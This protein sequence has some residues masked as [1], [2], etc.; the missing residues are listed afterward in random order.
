MQWAPYPG[1]NGFL[2]GGVPQPQ[3]T[4][5]TEEMFLFVNAK[6][7]GNKGQIFL[8][9]PM[10]FNVTTH[11][12]K[13]VNLHIY[14]QGA[15]ESGKKPGYI[16]LRQVVQQNAGR[17]VRC[18]VGGGDGTVMWFDSEATKH[19]VDTTTQV[20]LGIMPLGTGNDFSRVAGWG[21]NNPEHVEDDDFALLRHL[22]RQWAVAKPRGHDVWQVTLNV[23]ESKGK[24]L[25]MGTAKGADLYTPGLEGV[26]VDTGVH[27]KSASMINYF[28]IGQDCQVGMHFDKHR[29][30][31]QTC[32]LM[33]YALSGVTQEL[34]CW[35]QQRIGNIVANLY[36]G[37]D[38]RG[39]LVMDSEGDANEP[40]LIGN[41]ESLLF[42]NI[43]SFAGG[44]AQLWQQD[45]P[46]GVEPP[47]AAEH[48]DVKQ[49]PGD[50][51]LEVV[52]LPNIANI[53][54]DKMAHCARRVWSG[55]PYYIEYFSDD[56]HDVHAF[57]EVDGEFYHMV[58]PEC[59]TIRLQKRLQV[60]Q[61]EANEE[62]DDDEGGFSAC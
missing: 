42:L 40:E 51:R 55:G 26:E 7:G 6:S 41:P 35:N 29:T 8:Q 59:T 20:L 3:M 47:H 60:L 31:S 43:N 57:C 32:N 34:R 17:P 45:G 49:E 30:K 21:G 28:S 2:P 48:V 5:P 15:G 14:D 9:A 16:H 13:H 61:H 39:Q 53:A 36:Q 4:R 18:I 52:T 11:D 25:K 23:D 50:G 58:N 1:N 44:N 46:I 33:V 27:S 62:E 10:P 38:A 19:G 12:G 37:T 22:A 54:L 56:D 24:I